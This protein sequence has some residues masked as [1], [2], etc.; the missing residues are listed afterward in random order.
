MKKT[1]LFLSAAAT[2]LIACG[3]FAFPRTVLIEDFTNW[4]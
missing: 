1:A 2:L 3:A 4:G